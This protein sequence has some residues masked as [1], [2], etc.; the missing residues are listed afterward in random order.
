MEGQVPEPV[1]EER[2]AGLQRLVAGQAMA[3]NK[4]CVGRRFPVLLDR[5]GRHPGQLLGRSP[6]MQSV[7]VDAP[8]EL[9]GSMQMLRVTRANA[10][11]L[12]A[13]LDGGAS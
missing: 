4:A 3:F 12:A 1:K 8:V 10:N 7:F 9:L 6:Y 2:L 13:V 5:L 11:S